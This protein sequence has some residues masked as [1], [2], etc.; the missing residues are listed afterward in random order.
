MK[1]IVLLIA[2]V[3]FPLL[4]SGQSTLIYNQQDAQTGLRAYGTSEIIVR[5][6]I[7]D[8]HPLKISLFAFGPAP[9]WKYSLNVTTTEIV[10]RAIPKGAILLLR[11]ANDE[12]IELTN[13]L[14]ASRS[15]DFVGRWI[16]GTASK[17]YDNKGIY[18]VTRE[19]LENISAGVAKVR[20]QLSGETFD[21]IYKK[22]KFG[23]ALKAHLETID[24]AISAGA[25]LRSG[26]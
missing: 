8:E 16:E 25:D 2:V 6:G 10:S 11:T 12:V 22:D 14:E 19:Q 18:T 13:S 4:M 1:K 7:T 17:T 15:Q 23:A 9:D 21:T 5:N 20:M 26:F 3:L 24:S